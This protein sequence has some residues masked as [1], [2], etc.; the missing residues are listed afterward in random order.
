LIWLL[1]HPL[2]LD[3]LATTMKPIV[4][5][6]TVLV[7]ATVLTAPSASAIVFGQLDDFENGTTMGWANGVPGYVVNV[8]SGGPAGANDNFLQLTSDGVGQGGRLT[9]FNLQQWLGNYVT[10][11]V[12]S[13][14]LDL[15]NQGSTQLSIRLAFKAANT[16][17]APGY[18]SQAI[19]LAPGSGWQRFSI[20]LTA[21]NMIRVGN[22]AVHNT[23]FSTGVADVRIINQVGTTGLNG[24]F[25]TGQI[26]IDNIRAVPEPTSV[27]LIAGGFVLLGWRRF[28][29]Q[30]RVTVPVAERGE[31][32]R[33]G[34]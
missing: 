33:D 11:G 2:R 23:F 9:T 28:R 7:A 26:G 13:I 16:A 14:Q 34:R 3:S 31:Q 5:I 24:D 6:L 20:S 19:S 32:V 10:Q 1:F 4:P 22:A 18:L 21:S 30:P 12:T 15:R 17:D 27:A 25:V 29:R 8:N